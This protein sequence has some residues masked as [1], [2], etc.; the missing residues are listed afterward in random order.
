MG[1]ELLKQEHYRIFDQTSLGTA[2]HATQSFAMDDTY[3]LPLQQKEPHSAL[4]FT[5][6]PS[7]SASRMPVFLIL[8]TV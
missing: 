7:S 6:K 8:L 3:V 4:G 5:M 2:F 1:I